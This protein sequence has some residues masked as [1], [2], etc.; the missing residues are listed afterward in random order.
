M[1][2][3]F[4]AK[5]HAYFACQKRNLRHSLS[6]N[7]GD[8]S[9]SLGLR[10]PSVVYSMQTVAHLQICAGTHAN[11]LL[12]FARRSFMLDHSHGVFF[13]LCSLLFCELDWKQSGMLVACTSMTEDIWTQIWGSVRELLKNKSV[14]NDVRSA[15]LILFFFTPRLLKFPASI[16]DF[17]F[18]FWPKLQLKILRKMLN[19]THGTSLHKSC[20]AWLGGFPAGDTQNALY[21]HQFLWK[22]QNAKYQ[23]CTQHL[24]HAVVQLMG[25]RDAIH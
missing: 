10:A 3:T 17:I 14:M 18:S 16:K 25:F 19:S 4:C 1:H 7:W 9:T 15:L 23:Y 22:K 24:V 20:E 13:L 8:I 21:W 11:K 6:G 5:Q 12:P 2:F